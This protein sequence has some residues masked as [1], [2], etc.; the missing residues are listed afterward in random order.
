MNIETPNRNQ[1]G[2]TLLEV[3]VA[4]AVLMIGLV[5]MAAL[6]STAIGYNHAAYLR[7]QAIIPP[8]RL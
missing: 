3:L 5:A 2:F 8:L 6:Q 4:L 1:H 7:S